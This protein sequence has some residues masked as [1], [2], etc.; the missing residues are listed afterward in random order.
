MSIRLGLERLTK[1]FIEKNVSKKFPVSILPNTIH[2]GGTNG[3]GSICKLMQDI[4][5]QSYADNEGRSIKIGK[6]TSP[7][8]ITPEDAIT[9]NNLPIPSDKYN[10]SLDFTSSAEDSLSPFEQATIKAIE[11]FKTSKTDLNFMEVGCGGL[12]DSTNIIPSEDKILIVINKI[13]LDHTSILGDTLDKIATQKAGIINGKNN[14][15]KVLIN[16]ENEKELVIDTIVSHCKNNNMDYEVV[17]TKNSF[18]L[19]NNVLADFIEKRYQNNYQY[20][21]IIMAL[22]GLKHLERIQKI[23]PISNEAVMKALKNFEILGRLTRISDYPVNNK[24]VL[25]PLL[26]DGSHNNDALENLGKY[27]DYNFRNNYSDQMIFIISRTNSK[28]L[29]WGNIIRK[30]D[31]IIVTEFQDIKEMKWIKSASADEIYQELLLE[32]VSMKNIIIEL[33]LKIALSIANINK[34]LIFNSKNS[35][36]KVIVVGSLY[37]AGKVLTLYKDKIKRLS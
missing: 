3:K 9:I 10:K 14:L 17:D 13:S 1:F 36:F 11:Y 16:C 8:T 25:L 37:L 21:N 12:L 19:K 20:G 28:S 5:L 18:Y 23:R 31:I 15:C 34:K 30:N 22:K 7:Y 27:I 24:N 32:G 35:E 2:V 6:F 26:I 4:I 33:D 29:N